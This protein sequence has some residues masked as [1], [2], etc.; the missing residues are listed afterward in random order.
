MILFKYT[1]NYIKHE[2]NKRYFTNEEIN[3]LLIHKKN[4]SIAK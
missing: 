2:V 1:K 3:I 4:N